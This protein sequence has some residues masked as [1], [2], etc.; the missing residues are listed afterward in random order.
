MKFDQSLADKSET[1][2]NVCNPVSYL[3]HPTH[4]TIYEYHNNNTNGGALTHLI[5]LT[6]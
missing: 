4:S 1:P 2:V 5:V 6:F 3:K